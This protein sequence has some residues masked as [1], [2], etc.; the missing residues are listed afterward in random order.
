MLVLVLLSFCH[1]LLTTAGVGFRGLVHTGLLED[2]YAVL[3]RSYCLSVDTWTLSSSSCLVISTSEEAPGSATSK[4]SL[5][6]NLFKV[7]EHGRA[8]AVS[9]FEHHLRTDQDLNEALWQLSGARLVCHCRPGEECHTDIIRTVFKE[10]FPDAHD[11]DEVSAEPPSAQVQNYMAKL[12]EVPEQSDGSSADEGAPERGAGWVGYGPPMEVGVGYVSRELCD[13]QCLASPGRWSPEQRRY[14][15]HLQW[16][17]VVKL[18]ENFA[19]TYGTEELFTSLAFGRVAEC[20]FPLDEVR[21]LKAE[22]VQCAERSGYHLI[23]ETADR[24]NTPMT[25]GFF[26]CF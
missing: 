11:R 23:R 10:Q 13:G 18:F 15:Q 3:R 21:N 22:V 6:C 24:T 26:S 17:A 19:N 2:W 5:W 7:S 12:R 20:P 25:L 16:K 4:K 8:L 1:S 14:P 9:K